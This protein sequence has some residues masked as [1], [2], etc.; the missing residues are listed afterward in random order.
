MCPLIGYLGF[1][2]GYMSS[3]RTSP[4]C[5]PVDLSVCRRPLPRAARI[6]MQMQKHPYVSNAPPSRPVLPRRK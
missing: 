3:E 2:L 4:A 5:L 6:P 1:L